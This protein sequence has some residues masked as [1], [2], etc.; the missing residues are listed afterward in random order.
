MTMIN[1]SNKK[2]GLLLVAVLSTIL[3]TVSS[4][5]SE[6]A[7]DY[8]VR[9]RAEY[10]DNILLRSDEKIDIS[11][12]KI[13]VPATLTTRSE[14]M[15]SSLMG[16]LA[17]AKFNE[18]G[19]DSDDQNLQGKSK[20]QLERGEVAGHAGYQRSSTRTTAFLDTGVVGLSATRVEEAT[21]GGSSN[22]MFTEKNGIVLGADYSD[23]N[24]DSPFYRD[25]DDISGNAGWQHQWTERTR[26]RLQGIASRYE[27]DADIQV[28]SD[29]L[30]AQVGFDS[31]LSE[32]LSVFLLAG[33]VNVN[34]DYSTSSYIGSPEDDSSDVFQMNG[35]LNYRQ[36]RYQL[37]AQVRSGTRPSGGG[38]LQQT[39]QLNL[40]YRYTVSE[41]SRFNLGLV[42]G[43]NRSLDDQISNERDYAR[44]SVRLDYRFSQSWYVEGT[45]IYSYQ[46]RDRDDSFADTNQVFGSAYSSQ[47]NI[48]LIFQ[49][50]KSVWSR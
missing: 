49:P 7:L 29:S 20:Y 30:G 2:V 15:E 38:T 26:L 42:A 27:N 23:L 14:R 45:Y 4:Q 1:I 18:S 22:Y 35:S 9:G 19:Y 39:D 17:S 47:I 21:V 11:G 33:W 36:E 6:Y 25:Y 10:N 50:V 28:T 46:D 5:A 13:T 8:S 24:Y 43:L 40:N 3:L 48:S 31:S 16:E 41:R 32:Q 44:A 12:G 37:N 34:T